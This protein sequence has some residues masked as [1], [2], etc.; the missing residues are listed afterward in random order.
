MRA[1]RVSAFPRP[2]SVAANGVGQVFRG[3]LELKL[4]FR[5]DIPLCHIVSAN[6]AVLLLQSGV[7]GL[8]LRLQRGHPFQDLAADFCAAVTLGNLTAFCML[9]RFPVSG[10]AVDVCCHAAAEKIGYI[11]TEKL[12]IDGQLPGMHAA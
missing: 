2:F 11:W 7:V 6:Q 1:W 9:W 12:V 4:A 5:R 8:G 3:I 10:G